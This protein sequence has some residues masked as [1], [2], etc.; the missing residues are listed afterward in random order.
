MKF[1]SPAFMSDRVNHSY[2]IIFF[3]YFTFTFLVVELMTSNH[4]GG[5]F[6]DYLWFVGCLK[7]RGGV[8]FVFA[9]LHSLKNYDIR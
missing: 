9:S 2:S 8:L 4:V 7:T 1:V 5:T 3:L 6:G